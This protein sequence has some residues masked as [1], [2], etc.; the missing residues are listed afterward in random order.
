MVVNALLGLRG[1]ANVV[2]I[3][4]SWATIGAFEGFG[5]PMMSG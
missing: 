4:W 2:G 5:F 3:R 1:S